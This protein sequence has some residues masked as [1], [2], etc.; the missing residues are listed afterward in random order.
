M[1]NSSFRIRR[2]SPPR[3]AAVP[4]QKPTAQ[5]KAQQFTEAAVPK[6]KGRNWGK[7]A[8]GLGL[9]ATALT[10][11]GT[12]TPPAADPG[13]YEIESPEVVVMSQSTQKIDLARETETTCTG[14]GDSQSCTTENVAYHRVGIHVGEGVVQDLNGNLFA[15]PQLVSDAPGMNVANPT[16]VDIDGPWRSDGTIRTNPQGDLEL[17]GNLLGKKNIEVSENEIVVESKGFLGGEMTR[18]THDDG[19][20]T[21]K[22]GRS[23]VALV[24][25]QGDHLLVQTRYGGTIAEIRHQE[26]SGQYSVDHDGWGGETVMTYNSQ[27][28]TRKN[29]RWNGNAVVREEHSDGTVTWKEKSGRHTVATTTQTEDGWTDGGSGLFASDYHYSIDGGT[30]LPG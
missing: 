16:S 14:T 17:R 26:G 3:L 15:A 6:E 8:L 28:M 30:I 12:P 20:S 18:V 9:A 27:E 23:T 24:Q 4:A 7:L 21:I 5:P 11:C 1:I 19:V 25:S 13:S 22:E 10:A 2:Q 29:G